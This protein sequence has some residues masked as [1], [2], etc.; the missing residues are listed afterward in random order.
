MGISE[1]IWLRYAV[2][3][4]SLYMLHDRQRPLGMYIKVTCSTH[5]TVIK[6][7]DTPVAWWALELF[8]S[9]MMRTALFLPSQRK[10]F[11]ESLRPI[12]TSWGL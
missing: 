12:L 1:G 5:N 4:A 9:R 11:S 2:D 7:I 10:C 3:V 8:H 6:L